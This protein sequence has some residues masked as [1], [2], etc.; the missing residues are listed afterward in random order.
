MSQWDNQGC[1]SSP[2][3]I[4]ALTPGFGER[5]SDQLSGQLLTRGVLGMGTEMKHRE[6]WPWVGQP[7]LLV[8]KQWDKSR[9]RFRFLALLMGLLL[10]WEQGGLV[11]SL[12][13]MQVMSTDPL[14]RLG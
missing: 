6:R 11:D 2:G 4:L 10:W 7:A 12:Q 5:A 3:A 9:A 14:Q 13:E 1:A 8:P